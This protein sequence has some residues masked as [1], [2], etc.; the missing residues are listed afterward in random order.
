[1][2]RLATA[3]L[4]RLAAPPQL[5]CLIFPSQDAG[6]RLTQFLR[7]YHNAEIETELVSFSLRGEDHVENTRWA[8]FSAAI[9]PHDAQ[10]VAEKFWAV[11][12]DGLSSRHAEFCL[13]RFSLM[14]TGAPGKA[15]LPLWTNQAGEEAKFVIKSRIATLIASDDPTMPPIVTEDVFLYPK[16]MCAIA[17]VTRALLPDDEASSTA[18]VYG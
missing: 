13:E 8:C 2:Q 11:F 16:G 7:K 18:V 12:G 10:K 3:V 6:I 17:A 4:E 15:V 9:Y 5:D 1:V 14:G